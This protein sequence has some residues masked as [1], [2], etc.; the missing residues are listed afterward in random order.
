MLFW[1][2]DLFKKQHVF[3]AIHPWVNDIIFHRLNYSTFLFGTNDFPYCVLHHVY[4]VICIAQ[5]SCT[6]FII[7]VIIGMNL[8]LE[9]LISN[10]H[11][12]Y[13]TALS[14]IGTGISM[15]IGDK[16]ILIDMKMLQIRLLNTII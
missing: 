10:G 11:T 4:Y 12:L 16:I 14:P 7:I 15:L 2:C 1:T 6:R 5:L 9:A 8:L 13:G 3:A